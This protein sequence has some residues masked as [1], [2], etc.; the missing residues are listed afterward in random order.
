MAAIF[1]LLNPLIKALW[2]MLQDFIT[3]NLQNKNYWNPDKAESK[4]K[5]V[6]S[7]KILAKAAL[8]PMTPPKI[9][10]PVPQ[11]IPVTSGFGWRT[12]NIEGKQISDFHPGVDFGILGPCLAPEDCIV[13]KV[14]APDPQY[15][16]VF[17]WNP[18]AHTFERIPM[19]AG[20]AWTPYVILI[21][22]YSQNKYVYYHVNP[23]VAVGKEVLAGQPVGV[24]GNYG[25]CQ[26]AHLHFEVWPWSETE[27]S[28]Y[29]GAPTHWP[30]VVDPIGWLKKNLNLGAAA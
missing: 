26:G 5:S 6:D 4:A 16:V 3:V 24:S 10:Y 30:V 15:P 27:K 12:L 22:K 2:P 23:A 28:G 1:A 18:A 7:E 25:F 8:L 17:R 13:K 20:R 19:P 21:G 29:D 11:T 14:L 9:L